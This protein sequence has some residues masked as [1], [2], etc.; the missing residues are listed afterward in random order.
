MSYTLGEYRR[1]SFRVS[2]I[3]NAGLNM[4]RGI[5]FESLVTALDVAI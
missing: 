5:E 4:T 1:D 2:V 3:M